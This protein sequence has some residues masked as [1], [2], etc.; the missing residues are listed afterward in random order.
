M[1]TH[2]TGSH[3]LH[4]YTVSVTGQWLVT[5]LADVGDWIVLEF[6]F[7]PQHTKK[8]QLKT[9]SKRIY[10]SHT[11]KYNSSIQFSNIKTYIMIF[12]ILN[13]LLLFMLFCEIF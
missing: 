9:K 3:R 6:H 12:R 5:G 8:K 13:K 11:N 10:D 4:V 7:C 1:Y 2:H